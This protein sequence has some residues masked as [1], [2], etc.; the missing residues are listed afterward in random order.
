MNAGKVF[1]EKYL[2]LMFKSLHDATPEEVMEELEHC[3]RENRRPVRVPRYFRGFFVEEE[4]FHASTGFEMQVFKQEVHELVPE[5]V[6]PETHRRVEGREGPK[7]K[8]ILYLHGGA[9]IY[10][11]V[12]FHWRFL[13]DLCVRTHCDALMP[14]Y[15]KSPE[16]D[17]E[18]SVK[19][20]LEFYKSISESKQY[21]EIHLVGDSAGACLCLVVAQEAHKNGWQKPLTS[22]LLSP[23]VDLSHTKEDEMQALQD[24][25]AML[26]YDR[27]VILNAIWQGKLS[28]KHPWVS[29]VF[30]DFSG[31]DNLNVYYGSDEI[32]QPDDIFL[33]EAYEKAGKT[34]YFHEFE[35]MFHTFTMFPIPEGFK[36]TKKIAAFIKDR[37]LS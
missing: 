10:P 16:Y 6:V 34:G 36:A 7:R 4:K 29:P 33:K 32:L 11:P 18:Y 2:R 5:P 14:I 15:P 26:Q 19:T 12:F 13:H 3:R 9:F 24:K 37:Q 22:T 21:N 8:L 1:T 27:I 28:A 30:G 23:C 35:G 31:V 17:C 25:D 20:L